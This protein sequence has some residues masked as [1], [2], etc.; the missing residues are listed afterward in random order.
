[1]KPFSEYVNPAMAV[2]LVLFG[3][4]HEQLSVLLLKRAEEPFRDAWT[5]PGAFLHAE[6]RF[7]DAC[8][9]ILHNKLGISK[10]YLEQ[11]YTFDD[12]RR[13]PRGRVISV[14]YYALINPARF[15]VTAGSMAS[16][17]KWFTV[18]KLPKLGFDHKTIFKQALTRLRSKIL[19]FPLGFELLD[20]LFTMGELHRLYETILNTE[21]DRRNFSRKMQDTEFVIN[22]GMKREVGQNRHPELFRFNKKLKQNNFSLNIQVP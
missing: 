21:I 17:A 19:Y 15:A 16:D 8:T 9:R 20:E 2:D 10:V 1:M 3:Y 7:D 12:P 5:L 22:T 18:T 6:E 14:A 13:D 11:L 4:D